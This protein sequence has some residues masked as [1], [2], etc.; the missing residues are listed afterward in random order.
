MTPGQ[1]DPKLAAEIRAHVGPT[2][3]ALSRAVRKMHAGRVPLDD[4]LYRRA[5]WARAALQDLQTAINHAEAIRS[6]GLFD[7][8]PGEA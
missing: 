5:S 8:T 6:P 7:G 3:L 4:E 2:L 1:V